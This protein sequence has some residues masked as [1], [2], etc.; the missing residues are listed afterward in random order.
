MILMYHKV[1]AETPTMWWVSADAFYRQMAELRSRQVVYLDDYDAANP[2]HVC[3]TFDGVYDNVHKFAAPILEHF[4]YPYELFVVGDTIGH[5]NEFDAEEPAARFADREQLV[6]M[7]RRGG[8]LQWHTQTH[9]RLTD[10]LPLERLRQ[11]L[12]V[13][14]QLKKLDP[15]G[16]RW[17]G[18]PHGEF[19]PRTVTE[20]RK[21]FAGAVSCHQGDG[22]S[23][24]E[25]NRLTVTE[26]TRL[27]G[28]TIGV[29]IPSYNYGQYLGEATES[30]LR[31][32]VPPDRILIIDDGST[33]DTALI[34]T[35]LAKTHSEL[36]TFV[37]NETNCGIV[38]TF[39]KALELIETDYVVFL[40]ADNRFV[41]NY[42][43]Q[44]A[45]ALDSDAS[46]GVAYTDFA[47]FGA[48]APVVHGQ[49]PEA[50]RGK[51]IED[52]FWLVH[53]PDDAAEVTATMASGE[54]NLIHGS[55]MFRRQA[56]LDAGGYRRFKDEPEDFDLFRRILGSGWKPRKASGTWL[57]YRH[58]SSEQANVKLQSTATFRVLREA[59]VAMTQ[60]RD[61][62]A[63]QVDALQ[64][65]VAAKTEQVLHLQGAFDEKVK[66]VQ[67]LQDELEEKTHQ[68]LH[69]QQ[70]ADEK[71]RHV[72]I[73]QRDVDERAGQVTHFR[74]DLEEKQRH[75]SILQR[76]LDERSG[77]VAHFQHESQQHSRAVANL[78]LQLR[79]VED[80]LTRVS[81]ELVEARWESL[82]RRA[83]TLREAASPDPS[84][85]LA[86]ENRAQIAET[87]CEHLRNMLKAVQSD[88]EVH[89]IARELKEAQ[90][91]TTKKLLR[92][93]QKQMARLKDAV[94]QKLV[95]PFGKTQ[96]TIQQLTAATPSDG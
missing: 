17:L 12:R 95:L 77:Q 49:F 33:D 55:S 73:L 84:A 54:R 37:Q 8:R 22:T 13:P 62:R 7:V 47:L 41:A 75:V 63:R 67:I 87:E 85:M 1:A 35:A 11:E 36:I 89:R 66:H 48:R 64:R 38:P 28:A 25:L 78:K 71:A 29:V 26:K 30:V 42:I 39:N 83:K 96:R 14:P 60:Q 32:T 18:Y 57:E 79:L 40:G 10:D 51:I 16:F 86:L 69:F 50:M 81:N 15:A 43:E 93:Q 70:D 31:Q 58:H 24:L 90:L 53:F 46:I 21:L 91:R 44:S 3:I 65:D 74:R 45:D 20:A 72:A 59:V 52:T 23:P 76:E 34:A 82:T 88:I 2:K 61:E 4:G 27:R 6:D 5:G 19:T 80:K 94:S 56:W 92:Y 68:V 9:P